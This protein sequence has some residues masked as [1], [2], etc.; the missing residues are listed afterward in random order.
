[1]ALQA[2]PIS[3]PATFQVRLDCDLAKVRQASTQM[4]L[5]LADQGFSRA[6]LDACE[7]AT[8]EACNNAIKYVQPDARSLEVSLDV[9]CGKSELEIRVTDHTGG[10]ELPE[11]I[12]LP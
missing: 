7:L 3:R 1:M 12:K 8:V 6:D 9:I 10:F 5:F 4:K 11:E 2:A